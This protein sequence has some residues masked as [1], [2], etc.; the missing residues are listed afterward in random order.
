MTRRARHHQIS[1]IRGIPTPFHE[2][3]SPYADDQLLSSQSFSQRVITFQHQ[4]KIFAAEDGLPVIDFS[5]GME[6]SLFLSDGVHPNALG[7]KQMMK[8]AKSILKT[9]LT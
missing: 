1:V 5:E 6:P 3:M 8:H 7:H 9:I 4:L 2:E